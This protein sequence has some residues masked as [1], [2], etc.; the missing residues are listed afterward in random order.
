MVYNVVSLSDDFAGYVCVL[1]S[2]CVY[3]CGQSVYVCGQ[4][5]CVCA[6]FSACM[7]ALCI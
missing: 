4:S 6:C 5:V 2:V 7:R 3:V 1:R